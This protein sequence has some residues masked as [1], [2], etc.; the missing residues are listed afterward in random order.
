MQPTHIDDNVAHNIEI[1]VERTIAEFG[2]DPTD[3]RVVDL[4]N[5]QRTAFMR[6][7]DCG[8][9]FIRPIALIGKKH[10][11]RP[12]TRH[13]IYSEYQLPRLECVLKHPDAKY[14]YRKRTTDAGHD[15]FSI[16]SVVIPHLGMANVHTGIHI[17]CPA[18]WYYTVEGRSSLWAK[19]IMPYRGIIDPTYTG[20]LRVAMLNASETDYQVNKG[21]RIA[22]IILHKV[23]DFDLAPV[24]QFNPE[25]SKRGEDGFGSS[26]R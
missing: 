15:I 19:N 6:C 12:V 17:A 24:D 9:E 4:I 20:E 11:C 1:M 22:Q 3:L 16:E 7:R 21:D 10:S 13:S 18:G 8:E 5:D 26:G 25:Y 2:F 14:P 23:H